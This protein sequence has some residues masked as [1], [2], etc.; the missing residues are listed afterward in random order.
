MTYGADIE[1]ENT[2]G[3]VLTNLRGIFGEISP[4]I[5]RMLGD[6]FEIIRDYRHYI[7]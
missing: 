6:A 2:I 1:Q 7:R 3:G 5:Y 4:N